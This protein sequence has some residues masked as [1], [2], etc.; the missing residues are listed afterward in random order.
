MKINI[1]GKVHDVRFVSIYRADEFGRKTASPKGLR[2]TLCLIS[3]IDETRVG[4]D[5]YTQIAE[6]LA[7]LSHLDTYN[8][9]VGKKLA[10]SRAVKSLPICDQNDALKT[11]GDAIGDFRIRASLEKAELPIR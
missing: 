10:F 8:K 9:D 6:G 4:K 5:K 11:F 7:R 3:E 1:S 2:D